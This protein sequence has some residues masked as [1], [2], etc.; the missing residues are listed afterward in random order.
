MMGP[1]HVDGLLWGLVA[2]L[3]LGLGV[4][5]VFAQLLLLALLR[6]RHAMISRD[7]WLWAAT[8][9]P[10]ACTLV[11][12]VALAIANRVVEIDPDTL[13]QFAYV[14]LVIAFSSWVLLDLLLLRHTRPPRDDAGVG[15]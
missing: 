13:D 1:T 15:S 8:A 14:P 10:L 2:L 4:S 6:P 9:G 3:L 5:G 12:Y 11:G 7:R